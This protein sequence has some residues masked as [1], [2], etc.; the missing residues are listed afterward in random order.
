MSGEVDQGAVVNDAASRLADDR[1]L[2]A[3][4]QDLAGDAADRMATVA[5][6]AP[7]GISTVEA[8]T[9]VG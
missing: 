4:I 6:R 1:R 9:V 2:H 7:K 3:F 5:H 8:L